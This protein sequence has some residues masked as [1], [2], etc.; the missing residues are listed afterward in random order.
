MFIGFHNRS[1]QELKQIQAEAEATSVSGIIQLFF[2]LSL[3][4]QE[5]RFYFK[6]L[7]MQLR[8]KKKVLALS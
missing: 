5:Q 4:C 6:K 1:F 2:R 8:K 3:I 7:L